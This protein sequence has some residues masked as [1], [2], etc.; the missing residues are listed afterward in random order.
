MSDFRVAKSSAVVSQV[1]HTPERVLL[2]T[3]D[4]ARL[5]QVT[6]Q[7]VLKLAAAG[8]IPHERTYS[9]QWLFRYGP[10]MQ[11][12]AQRAAARIQ[13][14]GQLLAA[15]RVRMLKA[16]ADGEARQLALDFSARLTLVGSRAKGRKV[17]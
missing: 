17:A 12:V 10:V 9:G 8:Q 7:G 15:V 3:A 4:T 11:V 5:L 13:R 6:R 2:T 1:P 16:S 14:R